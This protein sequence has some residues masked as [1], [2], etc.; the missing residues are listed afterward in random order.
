M[1]SAAQRQASGGAGLS[2]YDDSFATL[3]D[4]SPEVAAELGIDRIGARAIAQDRFS[5][6][7]PAG[8]AA[9]RALMARTLAQLRALPAATSAADAL[10]RSVYEFFLRFGYFGRLR[11]VDSHAFGP[12]DLVADHLGGVQAELIVC[13]TDFQRLR[14][15][16][17]AEAYLA[18][19]AAMPA[20]VDALIAA[21]RERVAAGNVMPS[22]ITA[23]VVAE[24]AALLALPPGA[25][26]VL[27]RF[28]R[29]RGEGAA[30]RALQDLLERAVTPAYRRLHAFLARDYPAEARLGLW[31]LRDGDGFYRF[32]LKAHTT[33]DLGPDEIARIG[34]E[35]LARLQAEAR[36]AFRELGLG[37]GSLAGG[38]A[39]LDADPRFRLDAATRGAVADSIRRTV[40]ETEAALRPRFGLW[41]RAR[42]DVREIP[43]EQEANRHATY[44]PPAADGSRPGMFDVNVAQVLD[45]NRLDLLTVT[46]HEAMPGHHVQLTIAQELA[47]LPAFRRILTHDGYIEG[48]AKY[49][50]LLPALEG[51]NTD[52]YWQLARRRNELY[53]T[54]NLVLD[55]GIHARQWTRAQAVAFFA[56]QTGAGPAMAELVAD[57]SAARPAQLCA[58]KL[59]LHAV[60]GARRRLEQAQ[61][62]RFDLRRFHDLVLGDGSLPLAL[63][64]RKVEA[65]LARAC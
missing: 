59:G 52:P 43:P 55:T 5:D 42:V 13:L 30:T 19:V 7:T 47:G 27:R 35:E 61:G 16:A 62:A 56:Q 46:Y 40:A 36:A 57:R 11:G 26:P 53:S 1:A 64:E 60:L 2:F 21:L 48:W 63:F 6:I 49:A 45:T 24:L 18:R 51:V 32:L 54:A 25:H 33:T 29:E 23:R 12:C 41:P 58:Y 37:D 22:P 50:E 9:R 28:A 3:L 65:E 39:A 4:A 10:H 20:Q 14:D 8:D 44:V 15:A 34:T 17:D 38:F 31:R